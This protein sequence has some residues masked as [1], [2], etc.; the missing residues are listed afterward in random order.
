MTES[1]KTDAR[2][3]KLADVTCAPVS[4][5]P[6]AVLSTERRNLDARR[7]LSDR[8][9]NEFLEMP[10]TCLTIAQAARLFGMSGEACTRIFGELVNAGRLRLSPDNRY[11]LHSAA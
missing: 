2:L 6:R 10:G 4:V 5:S 11:R 7:I 3:A 8:I 1:A 9:R